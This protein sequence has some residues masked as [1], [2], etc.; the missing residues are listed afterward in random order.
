VPVGWL[1][2]EVG[3]T[4][5]YLRTPFRHRVA[6]L[7]TCL[8][9]SR[10]LPRLRYS[11]G[12]LRLRSTHA[13]A[14]GCYGYVYTPHHAAFRHLTMG[15]FLRFVGCARLDVLR[16]VVPLLVCY[17]PRRLVAGSLLTHHTC[18]THRSAVTTRWRIVVVVFAWWFSM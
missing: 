6:I 17:V 12:S 5:F 4:V 9:Y 7:R 1:L 3:A 14:A 10:A 2:V 8:C 16:F 13:A 15:S 18:T 11:G